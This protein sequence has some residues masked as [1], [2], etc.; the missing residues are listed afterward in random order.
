MKNYIPVLVVG[1]LSWKSSGIFN[2]NAFPSQ[3]RSTAMNCGDQLALIENS[4]VNTKALIEKQKIDFF[5]ILKKDPSFKGFTPDP[6]KPAIAFYHNLAFLTHFISFFVYFKAFLDQYARLVSRLIRSRSSI[7]GF[8]KQNIDG[9]KI[10]GGRLINWLR[11]STPSDFKD[12]SNLADILIRHVLEW[13]DELIQIRDFLVHNPNFLAE[14][15]ISIPLDSSTDKLSS[16]DLSSPK[17][18]GTDFEIL[19]YMEEAL[20][21]LSALLHETLPLLPNVD[22]SLLPDMKFDNVEG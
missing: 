19:L 13:I 6:N 7:F 22:F 21:H 5:E 10:S 16:D 14:F 3:L 15:N 1:K 17:I 8:N 12:S 2:P 20:K 18:P 11:N 4:L 9:R